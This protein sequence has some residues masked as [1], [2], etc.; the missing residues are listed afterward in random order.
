M[1][2]KIIPRIVRL[3]MLLVITIM[4]YFCQPAIAFNDFR[5]PESNNTWCNTKNE[6]KRF[7]PN[8]N[9]SSNSKIQNMKCRCDPSTFA[10]TVGYNN[11][12]SLYSQTSKLVIIEAHG[13]KNW[14]LECNIEIS[15]ND[16]L[17]VIST[18]NLSFVMGLNSYYI[19]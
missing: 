14:Y 3:D 15:N 8:A 11:V 6:H 13:N 7:G 19:T 5:D 18:F 10:C 16:A 9:M 4:M 2:N 12:Y 1:Q 17:A